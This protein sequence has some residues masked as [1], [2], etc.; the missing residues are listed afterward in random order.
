MIVAFLNQKGGVGKTT[1][2]LH[3]AGEWAGRGKRVTLV[4]ADPQGSALDWSQQRARE[5]LP[6]L[7]G[8]VGLARDTL[9]REA[10]ELARDADHV[11][12]DGPPR[13]AGLMRS[14]LLAADLVLIPVQP[15]PLDGWASAEMLAL[16]AEARIYRPELSAR[17]VLN[18]CGARTVLARETAE[19]LADHNPPVL[20]STIGQRVAFAAAA[21]TGRLVSELH[22]DVPGAR[23]ISALAAEIE[24]L[25]VGR[26]A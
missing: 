26:R 15:S 25:G 3:L 8:V 10:P 4:D 7:F 11:V 20:A 13:V 12:I 17:F 24:R 22:D 16:L 6:R 5:R 18:R 9:H 19:T 23:E 14:A 21:Q 1:L 2:A